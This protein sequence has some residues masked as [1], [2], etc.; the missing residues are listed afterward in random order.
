[1]AK[2][3]HAVAL[4]RKGGKRGG[5]ARAKN[6]TP[7]QLSEIGK[8][9]AAARWGLRKDGIGRG[10]TGDASAGSKDTALG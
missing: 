10:L 3:P 5:K 9:G 8:K 1:M 2:N 6:L 7:A 4:G